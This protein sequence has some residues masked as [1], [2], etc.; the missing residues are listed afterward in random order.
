MNLSERTQKILQDALNI[1]NLSDVAD[2]PFKNLPDDVE[3]Q[4]LASF[5]SKGRGSV[6]L[7]TGRFF[8]PRESKEWAEKVRQLDL[9]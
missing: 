8:G 3:Y 2:R 7:A 4:E 1:V 5:A 6:R 9:P